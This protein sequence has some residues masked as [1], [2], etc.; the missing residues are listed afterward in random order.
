MLTNAA[1]SVFSLLQFMVLTIL[2][3][4]YGAMTFG[5]LTQNQPL[6][7]HLYSFAKYIVDVLCFTGPVFL[8][9]TR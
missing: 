9:F 3:A 1:I 7:D 4:I 6:I 2:T 8:L 5:A